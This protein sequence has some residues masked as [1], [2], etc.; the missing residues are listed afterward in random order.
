MQKQEIYGTCS[1]RLV[2]VEEN[3]KLI[4]RWLNGK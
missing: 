4:A 3:G 2:I 1:N